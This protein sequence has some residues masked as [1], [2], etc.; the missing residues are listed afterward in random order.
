MTRNTILS[1]ILLVPMARLYGG[2]Y[3]YG[4][5]FARD[6]GMR[7]LRTAPPAMRHACGASKRAHRILGVGEG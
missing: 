5:K 1:A 4:Y 6:P 7:D 2:G 3:I